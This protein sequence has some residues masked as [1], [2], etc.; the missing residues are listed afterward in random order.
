MT[1]QYRVILR[2]QGPEIE[3]DTIEISEAVFI[4]GRLDEKDLTL[5]HS[6]VSREHAHITIRDDGVYIEDQGSSNGTIVGETRLDEKKPH[7]LAQGDGIGI[8]PF[9]LTVD[10]IITVAPP[11]PEAAVD[12]TPEEPP[13]QPEPEADPHPTIAG[14][15]PEPEKPAPKKRKSKAKPKS[16][17][18]APQPAVAVPQPPVGSPPSDGGAL[19]PPSSNG[20]HPPAKPLRGLPQDASN[21]LQ[22]LPAIYEDNEFFGKFLLI[23]ESGFAPYEWIVDNFDLYLDARIAP[24]E[25]LQWFG[26]WVDILV[27]ASIPEERQ[28][29]L[30]QELGPIFKAR[31]TRKS[32]L[33]HLELV[34]GVQ[35]EIAEP[36]QEFATFIVVL[37]LGPQENTTLNRD[38][39]ETIIESHR[40]IHT[41]FKLIIE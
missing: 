23:F 29:A 32:L 26:E 10:E 9:T 22:F 28:H 24:S 11:Q 18:A 19:T 25:F 12:T 4:I 16:K 20:L 33:R 21:W 14:V 36:E 30:A 15:P 8:G 3:Q 35:P 13:P 27:P 39:A 31:G 2:L 17:A 34:F 37:P 6:K 1:Q 40:P 5:K 41:S 38:L 7:K